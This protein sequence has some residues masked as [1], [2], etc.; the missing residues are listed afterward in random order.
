MPGP[1]S[2]RISPDAR[3][4]VVTE[5]PTNRLVIYPLGADGLPGARTVVASPGPT[6][7]GADFDRSGRYI[8]SQGNI[9]PMR[10]AVPDGS[11]LSSSTLSATG[12]SVITGAAATTETA[13]CWIEITPDGRFAYTTN[14]GSGS[15]TGFS[16]AANGAL[17][18]LTADGRTGV[19][20]MGTQPLDMA[21][22]DGFLYALTS[23]DGG[24][25]AFQVGS[26][27][28]LTALPGVRGALAVSVTGLAAY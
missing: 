10:A 3:L 21:H 20:G 18:S 24:I 4:L 8:L 25:H 6:P 28:S 16:I 23:G 27:G 22:A 11:T 7:F 26:N 1:G 19:T 14:T 15:I 13:A 5:K 2:I 12:L 17:A 9:G